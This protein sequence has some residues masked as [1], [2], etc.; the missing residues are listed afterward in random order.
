V[1]IP[2]DGSDFSRQILSQVKQFI[3]PAENE[4]ILLR[5]GEPPRGLTGKP[6]R[7]AS[8]DVS[9]LMY[10]TPRDFEYTRHPVYASQEY[11]SSMGALLDEL[12][13]EKRPLAEAGYTVYTAVKFGN[14]AA[15][16]VNFIE[17]ESIDLIAMTT[18][19]RSGLNRLVFGSVAAQVLHNVGIPIMLLRS[20]AST[21]QDNF[22][23][24][25]VTAGRAMHG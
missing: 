8:A 1:L 23:S 6:A 21:T 12:Q 9:V 13:A 20:L 22:P 18:H 2:L 3:S 24:E 17:D 25:V 16:I 19:G 11:D 14:A 7:P 10:D 4:L 5:V 15:E